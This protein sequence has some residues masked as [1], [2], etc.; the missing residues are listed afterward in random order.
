MSV[1]G[2]GFASVATPLLV[3]RATGSVA[4]MG[5]LTATMATGRIV[6]ALVAGIVADR[7][8]RRA[9]MILCDML[10]AVLWG[11]VPL[12]FFLF[13]PSIPLLFL[14][15]TIASFAGNTFHVA[16]FASLPALVGRDR[17]VTVN[18][19]LWG[20]YAFMGLVGPM[21]GGFACA[22]YGPVVGVGVDAF[23]FLVSAVSI[24]CVNFRPSDEV[25][26]VNPEL[27]P[28]RRAE[29]RLESLLFG[30][31]F[32]W[33]TPMLRAMAFGLA[34]I[35]FLTEARTDLIIYRLEHDLGAN[36]AGI[37]TVLGVASLGAVIAGFVARR[38]Y[39][40]LGPSGMWLLTSTIAS[41]PL[42]CLGLLGRTQGTWFIAVFLALISFGEA[43]RGIVSQSVRHE[44]TPDA[45]LG[46]VTS[47]YWAIVDLP[48][49][50]GAFVMTAIA[51]RWGASLVFGVAGLG[52]LLAA[53][54]AWSVL[55]G[56]PGH[57]PGT[58]SAREL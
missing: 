32:I 27:A 31:L 38:A 17:I 36:A 33:R 30:V 37:G 13:G 51:M 29:F 2:D 26:S 22:H 52:S 1:L 41:V 40:T 49:A 24:L 21:L 15:A 35:A 47:A 25:L 28:P 18:S 48:A 56:I 6:A 55:R 11:I 44:L 58:D 9:I 4:L 23:S 50:L 45:L 39:Q 19:W 3:L 14:V 53:L 10:R 5:A 12:V 57:V 54:L 34:A 7:W 43:M 20:T 46:R 42:C 16:C 8:D